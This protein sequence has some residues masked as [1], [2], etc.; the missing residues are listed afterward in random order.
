MEGLGLGA[1]LAA[2]AFWGFIATCVVAGIWYDIRKRD[3]QHETLRR[4]IESS[5]PL[6]QELVDRLFGN[7]RLDWALKLYGL[8]VL[9]VAPGLALLA[10]FVGYEH[11]AALLPLLGASALVG[12]IGIGLLV[13][14]KVVGRWYQE[15][16]A[17]GLQSA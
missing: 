12:C 3:A 13:A 1:G 7:K 11:S 16:G 4:L 15:D 5:Q 14:S 8:I 10:F 2:L 17:S 6:D 9:S